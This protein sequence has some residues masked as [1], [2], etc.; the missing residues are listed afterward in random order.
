MAFSSQ[1]ER[2]EALKKEAEPLGLGVEVNGPYIRI[3]PCKE[4]CSASNVFLAA[5]ID[6]ASAAVKMAR[7]IK[8]HES[9]KKEIGKLSFG[10]KIK[11]DTTELDSLLERVWHNRILKQE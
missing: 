8:R 2:Y 10:L 1:L 3:S 6:E 7:N 5:S 9:K 4:G 11:V